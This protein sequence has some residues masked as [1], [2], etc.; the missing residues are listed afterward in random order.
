LIW[1]SIVQAVAWVFKNHTKDQLA[2]RIS[3]EGNVKDPDVS[4]WVIIGQVLRNAFIQALYP[5]LENSVNIKSVSDD[6]KETKLSKAFKESAKQ[7]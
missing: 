7:K 2:T 1:E 5:S 4:I 3:F 6:K